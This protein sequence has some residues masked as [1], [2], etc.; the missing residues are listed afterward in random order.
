MNKKSRRVLSAL[1]AINVATLGGTVQAVAEEQVPQEEPAPVEASGPVEVTAVPEIAPPAPQDPAPAV[2]PAPSQPEPASGEQP[3]VIAPASKEFAPQSNEAVTDPK[4]A[5]PE[6]NSEPARV[7]KMQGSEAE[8]KGMPAQ[9]ELGGAQEASGQNDGSSSQNG[10]G[11]S[12]NAESAQSATPKAPSE[13]DS[14][15]G[16]GQSQDSDQSDRPDN[17]DSTAKDRIEQ[18]ISETAA[19]GTPDAMPEQEN[20]AAPGALSKRAVPKP[21]GITESGLG[22]TSETGGQPESPSAIY[23]DGDEGSDTASY[24]TSDKPYRSLRYALE[25]LNHAKTIY[26]KGEFKLSDG[27]QTSSDENRQYWAIVPDGVELVVDKLGARILCEA[28][29]KFCG[30]RLKRGSTLRCEDGGMLYMSGFEV[31]LTTE[32]GN[33]T[34]DSYA[35]VT[36]GNYKFENNE[37]GIH[38]AGPVLGTKDRDSV[39]I[40]ADDINNT[41]F[42]F[43][44][45][46]GMDFKNCTVKINSSY[47]TEPGV[48]QDAWDLR[49]DN[50]SITVTG[51]GTTFYIG[52]LT[53]QDSELIIG[54]GTRRHSS[55]IA[56]QSHGFDLTNSRIEVSEGK[57][58]AISFDPISRVAN[59]REPVYNTG[60]KT[61]AHITNSQLV[62]KNEGGTGLNIY[63]GT[64][65]F[66]NSVIEDTGTIKDALFSVQKNVYT[67]GTVIGSVEFINNSLVITPAK[68]VGN[69]GVAVRDA[70]NYI[71]TGGSFLVQYS[72]NYTPTLISNDS[73]EHHYDTTIPNN[74]RS[75]GNEQLAL[76][77]LSD[78]R[79]SDAILHPMNQSGT[80]YDYGV[81]Q[82]SSDGQK[83]VWV[84]AAP[85]VFKLN[86]D[87]ADP[88]TG[89][90]FA[91]GT[92]ENKS[93]YAMRGYALRDAKSLADGGSVTMP[94][95]PTA[96]G[97]RFV[98][99]FY[100]DN[101]VERE[102]TDETMVTSTPGSPLS[103]YARWALVRAHNSTMHTDLL[104]NNDTENNS[105]VNVTKDSA[106]ELS[107]RFS[108]SSVKDDL[109]TIA[110]DHQNLSHS[111]IR[112]YNPSMVFDITLDFPDAMS[113]PS[114]LDANLIRLGGQ[115]F[116]VSDVQASGNHL[117]MRVQLRR[118][119][120]IK[121]Y[122]N[123]E[124]AVTKAL[125]EDGWLKLAIPGVMV[126][127][128][129]P[130]ASDLIVRALL[131]GSLTVDAEPEDG[132]AR[133]AYRF[134][135]TGVQWPEGKDAVA[136]DDDGIRLTARVTETAQAEAPK[137]TEPE[138]PAAV[139]PTA[140]QGDSDSLQGDATP[141]SAVL[142][143]TPQ[144]VPDAPEATETPA[145]PVQAA[146]AKHAAV[147]QTGDSS[148][149][150]ASLLAMI[151][152]AFVALA[153]A[154]RRHGKKA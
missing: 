82:A 66:D 5:E 41:N 11:A 133:R 146:S 80:R 1:V 74:G 117:T 128:N 131:N 149:P 40:N 78:Q 24:G 111:A 116:K 93:A 77:T 58:S 151:G 152:S 99:W 42:Y 153:A 124:D 22:E 85:V 26:I 12:G 129:A 105:A 30:I 17:V 98:G 139:S 90:A 130:V 102:F 94:Q 21:A 57:L 33:D 37:K 114:G 81:N 113:L 88:V 28:S 50:A 112:L 52:G 96:P 53:M 97:Y 148:T 32:G 87:G 145:V 121:T 14:T 61:V 6:K 62:F 44:E 8:S 43:N 135:W 89:V 110:N 19:D 45:Y 106:H 55:G 115:D 27:T 150:G 127:S 60:D 49:L 63:G 140:P 126:K 125:D 138:E 71:V 9:D 54:T 136:G 154:L 64:V 4:A 3:Q 70:N 35:T 38:L 119:A 100:N 15:K 92:T 132:G 67:K 120:D 20:I 122:A 68:H 65:I 118:P 59:S 137:P 147:P 84:P 29:T 142:R 103:V 76:F 108:G 95:D 123:L 91:D 7:E 134:T 144:N 2:A 46:K 107:L 143:V 56:I 101:G 109:S 83:H 39:I 86:A 69:S 16:Q 73:S 36:D 18:P 72:T 75:N 79:T 47:A 31:A 34:Y 48:Y 104:L 25:N 13:A 23:V 10:G 51:L 141:H